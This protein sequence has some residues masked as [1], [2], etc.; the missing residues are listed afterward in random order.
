MDIDTTV[1]WI[2]YI[3]ARDTNGFCGHFREKKMNEVEV[4]VSVHTVGWL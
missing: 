1:L 2:R 3:I 4:A